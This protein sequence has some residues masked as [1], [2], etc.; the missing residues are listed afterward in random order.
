[1]TDFKQVVEKLPHGKK[2]SMHKTIMARSKKLLMQ[3][4]SLQSEM[5]T[6]GELDTKLLT[7]KILTVISELNVSLTKVGTNACKAKEI[8]PGSAPPVEDANPTISNYS[9]VHTRSDSPERDNVRT[10]KT[11]GNTDPRYN[12]Q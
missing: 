1:M 11:T 6:S 4:M 10:M 8:R 3:A 2:E 7:E 12:T 5:I 9:P